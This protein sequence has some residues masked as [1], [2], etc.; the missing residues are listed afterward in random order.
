MLT[1]FPGTVD[2]A[3]WEEKMASDPT[4]I[5]GYPLTRFWLIPREQRPKVY[6]P[7]PMLSPDEIR[8][9]TQSVWDRFYSI[10]AIWERASIVKSLAGAL[11]VRADVEAVPADV[12]EH[13]H[14]H[15][16][17]ARD[18]LG[19]TGRAWL[20]QAGRRLFVASPMPDLQVPN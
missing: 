19:A 5:A 7:H 2:F 18:A 3:K 10:P 15:R 16:Q 6:T 8:R 12:R 13:R 20:A 9:G 17:R 14:C 4:R 11:A 1:P